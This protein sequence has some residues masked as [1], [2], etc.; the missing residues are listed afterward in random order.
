[1]NKYFYNWCFTKSLQR[2]TSNFQEIPGGHLFFSL[3]KSCQFAFSHFFLPFNQFPLLY[4]S[5]ND[6]CSFEIADIDSFLSALTAKRTFTFVHLFCNIEMS[7]PF[8]NPSFFIK[9]F[10]FFIFAHCFKI[11]AFPDYSIWWSF[12][13]LSLY[14]VFHLVKLKF[15]FSSSCDSKYQI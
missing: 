8:L 3:T 10:A 1:M 6:D 4:F 7:E 9:S 15:E 14:L 13:K 12:C 5:F 2:L 11:E